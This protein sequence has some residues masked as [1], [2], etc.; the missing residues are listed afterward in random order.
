MNRLAVFSPLSLTSALCAAFLVTG[1]CRTGSSS[2]VLG[3]VAVK[4][5]AQILSPSI[6]R[7]SMI[8]VTDF[9]LSTG[10]FDP[11]EGVRGA[12]PGRLGERISGR[13]GERLPHP[14]ATTDPVAMISDV[15]MRPACPVNS[16]PAR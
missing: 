7:P 15:V 10:D 11:E 12:L 6:H 5:E 9:E 4:E 14:L 13:F 2:P 3:G 16:S 8:Y 1:G